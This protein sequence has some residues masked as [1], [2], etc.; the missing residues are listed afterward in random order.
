MIVGALICT[1]A[2]NQFLIVEFRSGYQKLYDEAIQIA[3]KH[4]SGLG[5]LLRDCA[6]GC[7]AR[8]HGRGPRTAA[9]DLLCVA[10]PLCRCEVQDRT[11][12]ARAMGRRP[13]AFP[14]RNGGAATSDDDRPR[15]A[16][17]D[18]ATA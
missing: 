8:T 15:P 18:G 14:L 4:P 17:G 1:F 7:V 3:L 16:G 12:V 6:A 5:F 2:A 9:R 13:A 11:G 10:K